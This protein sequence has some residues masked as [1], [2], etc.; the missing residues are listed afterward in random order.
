MGQNHRKEENTQA[1]DRLPLRWLVLL[2]VGVGVGVAVGVLGGAVAAIPAGIGAVA[3]L[4]G[5]VQ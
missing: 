3:M 2:S 4:H 1:P 5:V